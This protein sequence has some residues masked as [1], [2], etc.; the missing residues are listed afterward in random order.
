M[1]RFLSG[2]VAA[3][4]CVGLTLGAVA[5]PAAGDADAGFAPR[6]ADAGFS[7]GDADRG[8]AASD[9]DPGI[10]RLTCEHAPT[11]GRVRCVVDARVAEGESISWGDVILVVVPPFLRALR[12]RIGPHDATAQETLHWRWE[13]ALVARAVGRG[14]VEGRVRLV[15]CHG[16]TCLPRQVPVA[17]TV[18]VGDDPHG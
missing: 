17:G 13:L 18:L 11:P 2:A 10:A 1:S 3:A 8:P 14:V 15:V 7:A 6:D 12:G 16:A 5:V 9:P 4:A